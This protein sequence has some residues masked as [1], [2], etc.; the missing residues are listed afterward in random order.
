VVEFTQTLRVSGYEHLSIPATARCSQPYRARE[1]A[2]PRVEQ[3][4]AQLM[5]LFALSNLWIVR[6]KLLGAK[7]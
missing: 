3:N 1:G 5:T 2:L 6:S 7:A 4:T